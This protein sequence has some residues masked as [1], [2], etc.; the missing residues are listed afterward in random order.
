MNVLLESSK[1]YPEVTEE[2]FRAIYFLA[3]GYQDEELLPELAPYI[4][5]AINAL[6]SAL[7]CA[8]KTN[9][10]LRTSA[11]RALNEIVRVSKIHENPDIIGKLLYDIMERLNGT[12]D[13][14]IQ[15]AD[16]VRNQNDLQASLCVLLRIIIHKLSNL[17]DNSIIPVAA[18]NLMLLF[19]RVFNHRTC[20]STVHDKAMLATGALAYA[21]GQDF[22][23]HMPKLLLNYSEYQLTPV[24]LGVLGNIC[25][26]LEHQM[27]T[28]SVKVMDVFKKALSNP[29]LDRSVKPAIFS[30]FG[31]LALAIG[32][33]FDGYLPTVMEMLKEDADLGIDKEDVGYRNQLRWAIC[34]AY[35]GIL[36]GF[37][38][39]KARLIEPYLS[40][41][42]SFFRKVCDDPISDKSVERAAVPVIHDLQA[43][44]VSQAQEMLDQ[45]G[46][47]DL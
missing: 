31:D 9:F 46:G 33:H 35:S 3:Q 32:E 4:E 25:H 1:G 37:K 26:V 41:M 43:T 2:V 45:L 29:M 14:P 47:S 5:R 44:F 10:S 11:Y 39:P 16:D 34:R 18:D 15:S 28:S 8:D 22:E 20:G 38:G 24:S 42:L 7:D 23:K 13:F 6:I 17:V 19:F 27:L 12:F 30:C 36:N 40:C 21:I